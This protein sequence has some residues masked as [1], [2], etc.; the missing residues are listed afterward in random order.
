MKGGA[1]APKAPPLDP[2]LA[3]HLYSFQAK[4][5]VVIHHKKI[6]MDRPV[7]TMPGT[8]ADQLQVVRGCMQGRPQGG[9][10][11]GGGGGETGGILPRAPV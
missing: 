5:A 4:S 11:G 1:S 8:P 7:H 9:G 3:T 6:S 10:G 2:P